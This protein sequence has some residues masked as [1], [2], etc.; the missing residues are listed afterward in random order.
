MRKIICL[1]LALALLALLQ[2]RT[3]GQVPHLFLFLFCPLT[4]AWVSLPFEKA[5]RRF[6]GSSALAKGR[7]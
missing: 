1:L 5:R 4:I 7:I 2:T 3:V 6:L